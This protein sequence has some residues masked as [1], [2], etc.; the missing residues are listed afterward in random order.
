MRL[1]VFTDYTIRTLIYLALRPDRLVTIGD[2]AKAYRISNNHLMK[3]VHQLALSGDVATVRGQHGGLR[4][5]RPAG[6]INIGAV[7]R[8]SEA[9]LELVPCF[10]SQSVCA[11]QPECVLAHALDEALAAFLAALDRYTLA[12]M[13]RPRAELARLLRIEEPTESPPV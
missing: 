9:D 3:V 2:I 4:L 11:I 5:G 13:A 1:T 7:V 12:D 8:R 6:E 10:G